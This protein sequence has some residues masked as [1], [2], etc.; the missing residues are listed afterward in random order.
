MY[1]ASAQ[2]YG[3]LHADDENGWVTP[4]TLTWR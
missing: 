4:R 2:N 3:A 1:K